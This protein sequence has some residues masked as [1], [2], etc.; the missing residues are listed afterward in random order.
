MD[1]VWTYEAPYDT[2][3][4]IAGHLAFYRDRVDPVEEQA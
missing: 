2:V 4:S 1:A 3:A